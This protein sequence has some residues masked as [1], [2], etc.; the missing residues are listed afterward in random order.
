MFS[1]LI[2]NNA[3]KQHIL[4]KSNHGQQIPRITQIHFHSTKALTLRIQNPKYN[5]IMKK[6]LQ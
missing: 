3:L 5:I 1:I 6:K 4:I 2:V